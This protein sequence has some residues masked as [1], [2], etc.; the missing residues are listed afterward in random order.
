MKLTIFMTNGSMIEV[1]PPA[2]F[3]FNVACLHTRASGY[4]MTP[5]LYVPHENILTM[6][7]GDQQVAMKPA[8]S[9]LQ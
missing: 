7:Y 5:V 3:N 1:D 2:D 6:A 4:F 8:G 9:T